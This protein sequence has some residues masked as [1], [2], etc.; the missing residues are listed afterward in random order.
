VRNV[1]EGLAVERGDVV[2]VELIVDEATVAPRPDQTER[3]Q[4]AQL[5]RDGRLRGT[6]RGGQVADAEFAASECRHDPQPGR[7]AEGGEEFGKAEEFRTGRQWGGAHGVD[8]DDAVVADE[9]GD[10]G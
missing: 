5:M 4:A 10:V 3:T 6:D 8:V 1:V 2:V 7:V 9:V